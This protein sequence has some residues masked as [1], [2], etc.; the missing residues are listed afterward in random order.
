ML[1]TIARLDLLFLNATGF[2]M[3]GW[4]QR[5]AL[6]LVITSRNKRLLIL[7]CASTGHNP[8]KTAEFFVAVIFY[9]I[10]SKVWK[11]GTIHSNTA[12]YS[13]G[14]RQMTLEMLHN[15]VN[16]PWR[17]HQTSPKAS[18]LHEQHTHTLVTATLGLGHPQLILIPSYPSASSNLAASSI[19]YLLLPPNWAMIGCSLFSNLNGIRRPMPRS[20]G[21]SW[22]EIANGSAF[23]RQ[24]FQNR[25]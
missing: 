25:A 4:Q 10:L 21:L 8:D 24:T 1:R 3:N 6:C 9:D 19:L 11:I 16:S 14:Y 18:F 2:G 22:S 17:E 5:I 23:R 13:Y 12:F 7:L 20:T 15:V